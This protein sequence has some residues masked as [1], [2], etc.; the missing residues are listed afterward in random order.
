[1]KP[2]HAEIPSRRVLHDLPGRALTFLHAIGSWPALAA[3]MQKA[4]FGS[5]DHAEGWRLLSA[6]CAYGG[7]HSAGYDADIAVRRAYAELEAWVN[8]HFGRYQLALERLHPNTES[9]FLGIEAPDRVGALPA[10]MVLLRRLAQMDSEE[11]SPML[12][13]LENRGLTAAE[14][15]KLQH[16][17]ETASVVAPVEARREARDPRRAELLALYR[18][19][20][21]WAATARSTLDRR[22][23]LVALGLMKRG[24]SDECGE[25]APDA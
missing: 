4:G 17:V 2:T 1:M 10:V 7:A 16:W 6:V 8:A 24:N 3:A 18:W 12:R 15:A 11:S 9:P 23:Y 22:Q 21:D 25:E 20:T 5:Q 19:H 14:R 13:T